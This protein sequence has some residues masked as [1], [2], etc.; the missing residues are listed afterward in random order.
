MTCA[1]LQMD[2]YYVFEGMKKGSNN[3]NNK[4]KQEKKKNYGVSGSQ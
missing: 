1:G 3:N 2:E 4:K